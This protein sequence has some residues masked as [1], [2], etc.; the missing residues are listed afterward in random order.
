MS[1]LHASQQVLAV[2][3]CAS[4][5]RFLIAQKVARDGRVRTID[6]VIWS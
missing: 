3:A 2:T 6:G 5:E 1:Q 4:G